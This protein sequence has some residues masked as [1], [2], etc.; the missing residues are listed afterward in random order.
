MIAP[1]GRHGKSLAIGT[2]RRKNQQK[3]RP[4]ITNS[5]KA[6][7]I[8]PNFGQSPDMLGDDKISV[9]SRPGPV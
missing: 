2:K 7:T 6:P 5:L 4:S 1:C 9:A 3:Q 8:T